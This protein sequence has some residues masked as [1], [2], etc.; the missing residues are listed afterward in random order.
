MKY[1]QKNTSL[2]QEHGYQE[3]G[4]TWIDNWR[5]EQDMSTTGVNKSED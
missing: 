1:K 2:D 3:E 5:Q 4:Q